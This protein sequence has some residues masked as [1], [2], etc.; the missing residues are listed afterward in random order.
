MRNFINILNK[1]SHEEDGAQVVEYALIVAI[2][3][4]VLV[5]LLGNSSTGITSKFS[6]FVTRVG[7]CLTSGAC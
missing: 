6:D 4:I 5:L 2:V 3:S 1:F 7:T